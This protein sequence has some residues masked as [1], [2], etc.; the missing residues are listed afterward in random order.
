MQFRFSLHK[1][2]VPHKILQNQHLS[3]VDHLVSRKLK[4]Y[5]I[6]KLS[7]FDCLEIYY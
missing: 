6:L 1:I 2:Q 7:L 3:Y 4:S 5:T